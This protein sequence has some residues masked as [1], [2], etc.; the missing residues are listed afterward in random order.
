V[1]FQRREG[2]VVVGEA[3]NMILHIDPEMRKARP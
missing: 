1:A 2:D 3:P